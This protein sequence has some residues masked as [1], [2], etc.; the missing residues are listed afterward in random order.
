MMLQKMKDY[1]LA[2]FE[3]GFVLVVLMI[4]VLINVDLSPI[5]PEQVDIRL[6]LS[7]FSHTCMGRHNDWG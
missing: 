3:S 7:G 4:I 6:I 1:V 5:F 2:N